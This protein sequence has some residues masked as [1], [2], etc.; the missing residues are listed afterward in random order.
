M[1]LV[2]SVFGVGLVSSLYLALLV[3]YRFL[4]LENVRVNVHLSIFGWLLRYLSFATLAR[5]ISCLDSA[6]N[7]LIAGSY[8]VDP[9]SSH[10]LVSKIKPCMSKYKRIIR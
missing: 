5:R 8:L 1:C 3:L 6:R 7:I 10:M 4:S 2:L 9:A